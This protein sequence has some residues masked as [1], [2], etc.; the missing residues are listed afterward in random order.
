MCK[1]INLE[2]RDIGLMMGYQCPNVNSDHWFFFLKLIEFARK[3]ID[4]A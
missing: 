4:A 1:E 2:N 3:A